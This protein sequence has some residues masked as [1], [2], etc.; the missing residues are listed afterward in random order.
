LFALSVAYV[1]SFGYTIVLHT[2]TLGSEVYG[3]LPYDEVHLTLNQ[4][5]SVHERF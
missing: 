4:L 3:Q 1:K 5:D 2:D